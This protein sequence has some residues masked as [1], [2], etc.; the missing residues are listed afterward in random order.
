MKSHYMI[1]NMKVIYLL[2]N[3]YMFFAAMNNVLIHLNAEFLLL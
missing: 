1:S 3:I 2:E